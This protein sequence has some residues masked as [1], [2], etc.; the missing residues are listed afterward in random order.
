MSD[1]YI[2]L[3]EKIN[4]IIDFMENNQYGYKYHFESKHNED[5]YILT[6]SIE[7]K[8]N[9]FTEFSIKLVHCNYNAE[10]SFKLITSY[11]E[12]SEGSITLYKFDKINVDL[13]EKYLINA[14][15]YERKLLAKYRGY[16]K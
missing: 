9:T 15:E 6:K 13:I 8:P 7:Y 16:W 1:K 2:T 14:Q 4:S 3:E 10:Y 5:K 11:G 12:Y